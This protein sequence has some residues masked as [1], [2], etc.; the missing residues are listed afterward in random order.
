[1]DA[2]SKQKPANAVGEA[3][4]ADPSALA[5]GGAS[6]PLRRT[7]AQAQTVKRKQ[8]LAAAQAVFE[9]SGYD[10]ASMNDIAAEGGISKPT[11]YVYFDSKEKLFDGLIEDMN[12]SLPERVLNLDAEN[13]DLLGVLVRGGV[14]L[15]TKITRPER[16]KMLRVVVGAAG[17]F[18]EIGQKYFRA[19][20][21]KGIEIFGAYLRAVA[22]R[23]WLDV[24]DPELAAYHLLELMQSVHMR[25]MIFAIAEQPSETEIERTVEA[26]VRVFLAAYRTSTPVTGRG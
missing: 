21:G 2:R 14:A 8:I 24:P 26:G 25:R 7:R 17:K 18:P 19:G 9:R 22:A 4:D 5:D 11:L 20:P 3:A 10:G 23:G 15:L 16:I 13:P 12:A 1:M 6:N